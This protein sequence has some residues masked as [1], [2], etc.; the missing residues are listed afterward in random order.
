MY[1]TTART[2][3]IKGKLYHGIGI[4]VGDNQIIVFIASPPARLT[5]CIIAYNYVYDTGTSF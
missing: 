2:S 5:K 1:I 3:C 4:L